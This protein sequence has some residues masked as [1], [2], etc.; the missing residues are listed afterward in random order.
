MTPFDKD[1]TTMEWPQPSSGKVHSY[2]CSNEQGNIRPM[3]FA[4]DI[5]PHGPDN[6][7]IRIRKE[8]QA[9]AQK[10]IDTHPAKSRF[11]ACFKHEV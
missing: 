8:I 10:K 1:N 11:R 9:S 3:E 7:F 6:F 2:S 4:G 5:N